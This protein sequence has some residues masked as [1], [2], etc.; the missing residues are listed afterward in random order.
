MSNINEGEVFGRESCPVSGKQCSHFGYVQDY[1]GFASTSCS[2]TGATDVHE[3]FPA[4]CPHDQSTM[5][6]YCPDQPRIMTLVRLGSGKFALVDDDPY[7]TTTQYL[8]AIEVLGRTQTY[9]S[10]D[11]I[12]LLLLFLGVD[13]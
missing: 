10:G 4:A 3:L 6:L 5:T 2:L 11:N 7:D 1:I 13:L 9:V 8:S 12:E